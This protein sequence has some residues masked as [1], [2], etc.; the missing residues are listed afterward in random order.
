ME[1]IDTALA[2]YG[3]HFDRKLALA[4]A[5]IE[6]IRRLLGVAQLPLPADMTL[7]MKEEWLKQGK[8]WL[9]NWN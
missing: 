9:M 2:S 1:E 3:R 7:T 8:E 6:L 4:F 5:G